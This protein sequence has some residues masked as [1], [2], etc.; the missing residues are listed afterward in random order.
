MKEKWLRENK[1][2][3]VLKFTAFLINPLLA[4]MLS[5]IRLKTK[6]SF[7]ILFLVFISF[8][9]SLT[10]SPIRT[11]TNN[12]DAI[13]YR[14]DFEAYRNVTVDIY[15]SDLIDYLSFEGK[16]DFYGDTVYFIVSRFSGNYHLMFF[17]VSIV[18]SIF[19]LKS[20]E[21]FVLEGN[22]SNNLFCAILL[23]AFLVNQILNINAFRFF[24]AAWIAVYAILKVYVYRR[25]KYV[26]L[27]L[28]TPF[29]HGAFW[30]LPVLL[31]VNLILGRQVKLLA[32]FFVA[33]FFFAELSVEVFK[34]SL[35]FLPLS[36]GDRLQV[37]LDESYMEQINE[38]GNGLIWIKRMIEMLSRVYINLLLFVFVL[39][40]KEKIEAGQCRR[41][42]SFLLVL[43]IFVNFTMII[44]S[45]GSRFLLLALP[46]IAYISLVC[47]V[48]RKYKFLFYGLGC[49]WL[50]HLCLPF[51][52]YLF[53]CI[54]Y[55]TVLWE[56][57]FFFNSP[58]VSFVKYILL[59]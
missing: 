32:I 57:T 1:Y 48:S 5:I 11:D 9:M 8:G 15:K 36:L 6:S 18:F 38:G 43:M 14:N 10:I 24:T 52:I 25:N 23:Y 49:I 55:Y 4:F 31:F 41:L 51:S 16:T 17:F 13:A 28:L 39:K 21:I 37:Y 47:F 34:N 19:L 7:I 26:L 46:F 44:P 42:F 29:F 54:K 3:V 40:Y 56:N 12:F 27:I 20:L 35:D 33:S 22:Y 30:I 53:P 59:F 45:V 50:I 58:L 2:N